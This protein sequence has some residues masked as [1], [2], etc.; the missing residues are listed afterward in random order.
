MSEVT[1]IA[2]DAPGPLLFSS[3]KCVFTNLQLMLLDPVHL[4]IVY[5]QAHGGRRTM[6]QVFLRRL[7]NKLN[8][9]DRTKPAGYWG[10][11]FT[12]SGGARHTRDVEAMRQRIM[13][14]S[15]PRSRAAV[16]LD[17][18]EDDKPW[19]STLDYVEAPASAQLCSPI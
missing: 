16:L 10:Q 14:G 18:L 17:G 13:T 7:Q 3:L 1:S 5:Q 8:Q 15:L 4:V 11:P 6:G 19:Y 12:G 2:T 9:V